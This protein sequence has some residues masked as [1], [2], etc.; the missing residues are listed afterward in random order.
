MMNVLDAAFGHPRG[1]LGRVG[2][3]I[4]VHSTKLRNEWTLSL[5]DIQ[6]DDRILEVTVVQAH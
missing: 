1:L 2:G 4:M 5:L 3:V 6:P